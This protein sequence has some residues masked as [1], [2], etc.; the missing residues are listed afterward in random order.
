M[1]I[2]LKLLK[3]FDIRL[4]ISERSF[5]QKSNIH[6]NLNGYEDVQKKYSSLKHSK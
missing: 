6:N 3:R 5:K 1:A 2:E 4:R